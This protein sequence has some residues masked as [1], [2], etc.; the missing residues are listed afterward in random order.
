MSFLF[1]GMLLPR[2]AQLQ[3]I[4]QTLR[5]ATKAVTNN[6]RQL[7]FIAIVE[8]QVMLEHLLRNNN[9][10]ELKGFAGRFGQLFNNE[11]LLMA[12]A[13]HP[14]YKLAY[15]G[16]LSMR[17]KVIIKGRVISE[18]L[19]TVNARQRPEATEEEEEENLNNEPDCGNIDQLFLLPSQG[20]RRR[21]RS[22]REEIERDFD[23][24]DSHRLTDSD[25]VIS[26]E[27]FPTRHNAAW[28]KLFCKYNSPLPS[29]AAVER[30]FSTGS[31]V[32]RA[33][34]TNLSAVNVDNLIF[35][36]GNKRFADIDT[37]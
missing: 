6:S 15:V 24:W 9:A 3:K 26:C 2:L 8:G 36:K 12:V 22:T 21:P 7:P 33:S 19:D 28:V 34:R 29:S 27:H 32:L 25:S 4:L 1:T 13:V 23:E 35:I 37:E 20:W 14:R 31:N 5:T 10:P 18:L 16:I 17:K 30:L 11:E